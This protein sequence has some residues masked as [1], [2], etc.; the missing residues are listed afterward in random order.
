M[1]GDEFV[2]V[3]TGHDY[4][5]REEIMNEFNRRVERNKKNREVVIAAGISDFEAGRDKG[6][7]DVFERADAMMYIRKKELKETDQSL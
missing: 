3:L 2:V 4:D 5:R 7:H 6:Y 1:G